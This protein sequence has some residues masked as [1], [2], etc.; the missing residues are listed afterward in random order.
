MT[1]TPQ[2][3]FTKS[4]TAM[5]KQGCQ[6]KKEAGLPACC[7]AGPGD[8]TCAV[9]ALI[10]RETAKHWDEI[11]GIESIVE[12]LPD[13]PDWITENVVLLDRLQTAHDRA[14]GYFV[15]RFLAEAKE[16]AKDYRLTMPDLETLD[17]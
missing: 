16:I 8:L 2:E 4:V 9:G 10:D 14:E 7:Y 13:L 3:I 1:M 11:G 6:S 5:V 12:Q 17:A 15:P